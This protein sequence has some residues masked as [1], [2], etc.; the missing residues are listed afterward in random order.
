VWNKRKELLLDCQ[1]TTKEIDSE[2]DLPLSMY[3]LQLD[4]TFFKMHYVIPISTPNCIILLEYRRRV[5][6]GSILFFCTA[7]K[8][9]LCLD[10]CR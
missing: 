4:H 8:Q 1:V 2:D 10:P 3:K 9:L 7:V 5:R 6:E